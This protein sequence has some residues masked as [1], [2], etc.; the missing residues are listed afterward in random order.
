M[1][2]KLID[3][4]GIQQG[5]MLTA[6]VS[7][8]LAVMNLLPI[9]ALDGGHLLFIAIE[10]LFRRPVKKQWQERIVQAGF[11]SLL[12]LMG[13]VLWNDVQNTWLHPA[14]AV[15]SHAKDE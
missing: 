15:N 4:G 14:K 9:P 13:F 12:L 1:G 5:L 3:E 11:L 6:V 2:A 7:I 10:A 8:L